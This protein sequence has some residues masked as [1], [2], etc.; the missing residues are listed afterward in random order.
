MVHSA[1]FFIKTDLETKL[2]ENFLVNCDISFHKLKTKKPINNPNTNLTRNQSLVKFAKTIQGLT[3]Q[4]VIATNAKNAYVAKN[5]KKRSHSTLHKKK[6]FKGLLPLN[7]KITFINKQ[8]K[9]TVIKNQKILPNVNLTKPNIRVD[10]LNTI[11]F[12]NLLGET[13]EIHFFEP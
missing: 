11:K 1:R 7:R 6:I 4:L 2:L 9:D 13:V 12:S 8:I 10:E 3:E 5:P